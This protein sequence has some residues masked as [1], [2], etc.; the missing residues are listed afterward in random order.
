MRR[1]VPETLAALAEDAEIANAQAELL[2]EE[3]RVRDSVYLQTF[4]SICL[5]FINQESPDLNKFLDYWEINGAGTSLSVPDNRNAIRVMTIHKSKG[6]EFRAVVIPFANWKFFDARK[7]GL[8]WVKPDKGP[9]NGLALVPVKVKKDLANTHFAKHYFNELLQYYVDN[10]NLA[11]VAF[12]RAKHSLN[13]ICQIDSKKDKDKSDGFNDIGEL[14]YKFI[15]NAGD[16]FDSSAF[17]YHSITEAESIQN[18]VSPKEKY[19]KAN[20]EYIQTESRTVTLESWEDRTLI[21]LESENYFDN[22]DSSLLRGRVIHSIFENIRVQDDVDKAIRRL[23]FDG[24]IGEDEAI[25]YHD[26]ILE[27]LSHPTVTH[28]FDGSYQVKTEAAILF[29]TEKR[30]DRV[31]IKGDEVVVVD[32]KF[33]RRMNTAHFRQVEQYMRLIRQMGYK[34]VEGYLWYAG[35]GN[36]RKVE[37]S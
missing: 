19:S 6:L 16:G 20:R 8:I 30:P 21:H 9:F 32:Y 5:D 1:V 31:M 11:Y 4:M 18:A 26:S 33:G 2:P 28:W 36:I 25:R 27:W 34:N 14:L 17:E 15:Q 12:T 22:E 29:K 7:A 24:M 23:V 10:L 37:L 3:L 13:I 35:M